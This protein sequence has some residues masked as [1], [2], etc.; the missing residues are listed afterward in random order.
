M[1]TDESTSGLPSKEPEPTRQRILEAA[2][3]EFAAHGLAGAR[4]DRIARN[5]SASKERLYA[6]YR[7]KAEL[8]SAVLELN[9]IEFASAVQQNAGESL[10]EFAGALYDH[11]VAHPEYLRMIDWANLEGQEVINPPVNLINEFHAERLRGVIALQA[12]GSVD[13]SWDPDHLNA[14]VF[15]I[16][17]CWI[18]EPASALAAGRKPDADALAARRASVVRAVERLVAPGA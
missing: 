10:P 12:A 6:Y 18:H 8:F 5:A 11:A 4:I 7:H 2:R 3:V 17:S 15:G 14:L 16:V 9:L 1:N 13:P